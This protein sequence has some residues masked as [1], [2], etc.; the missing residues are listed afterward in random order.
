M[1]EV[2]DALID[3]I[4]EELTAQTVICG[5]WLS[6]V[7]NELGAGL[8][9]SLDSETRLPSYSG[10]LT[11]APVK[12]LAE[13]IKSWNFREASI[14]LAAI[15]S[16]Y[17]SPASVIGQGI[18]CSG[19][20]FAEDRMNDPFITSQNLVRGKKV[21][22]LGHFPYLETFFEPVCDL[23][24]IE[25]E[26]EEGDYPFSAVEYILPESDLVFMSSRSLVDKTFPRLLE[27]SKNA[28]HR[29]LVGPT[30]PLALPLLEAGLD[31]LSGF[32]IKDTDKALRIAAG[33]ENAKIYT[34]GQ[35]VSLKKSI[36]TCLNSSLR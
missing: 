33:A 22:V 1:W 12:R 11:G 8:G 6:I 34:S 24:I 25:W 32:V 19:S 20:Q 5:S 28:A 17:N 3:G 31:D 35:K 29:V 14:G 36:L 27:L 4:P 21:A 23:K 26:P 18:S 16:Y 15:N 2:Y 13:L 7:V 10:S 9:P 30:T